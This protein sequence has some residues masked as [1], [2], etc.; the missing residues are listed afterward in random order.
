MEVQA[1]FSHTVPV[2]IEFGTVLVV[3]EPGA[4]EHTTYRTEGTYSDGRRPDRVSFGRELT[5]DARRRDFTV[6]ALYLDPLTDEVCDPEGGMADL[7][8]GLL[9]AIGGQWRASPDEASQSS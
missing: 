4:L 3:L 9:R 8:A 5:E 7:R 6:N 2:G 1:A